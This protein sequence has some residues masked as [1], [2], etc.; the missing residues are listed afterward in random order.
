MSKNVSQR[1]DSLS[2]SCDALIEGKKKT[3]QQDWVRMVPDMAF[4][5]L[6]DGS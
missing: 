1:R 2:M 6:G 4:R 5:P 3:G